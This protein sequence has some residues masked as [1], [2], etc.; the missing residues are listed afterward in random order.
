[1]SL[2]NEMFQ[3]EIKLAARHASTPYSV[4]LIDQ[5][6][7]TL[8]QLLP[9]LSE[10]GYLVEQ[11][12]SVAEAVAQIETWNFVA[13]L[14]DLNVP[15]DEAARVLEQLKAH[16]GD[17][18]ILI[19]TEAADF[20]K[21]VIALRA[22]VADYFLKPIKPQ[23]LRLR[24][25][26]FLKLK[27]TQ[28]ELE[29]RNSQ[30]RFIV[31]HL[32]AGAV[33][34]NTRTNTISINRALEN[35]TGY[36]AEELTTLD[37]WFELLFDENTD[38]IRDAYERAR[39]SQ[40]TELQHWN[41][42]CKAGTQRQLDFSGFL[43]DH[44]EVWLLHDITERARTEHELK[45]RNHAIQAAEN[46]IIICDANLPDQPI[47]FVNAAFEK[48]TGYQA[49]E[50]IGRNARFLQG[51]DRTQPG[52]QEII[53][54]LS[55][56]QA[57]HV[58]MRNYRKNG[59]MFWNEIWI[60]PVKNPQ[61]DITHFI[62]VQ[63]DIT[64]LHNMMEETQQ[65]RDFAESILDTAQA[66]ILVLDND[67]NIVRFNS[68]MEEI[69]GYPLSEVAG[70]DWFDLFIPPT[71]QSEVKNLFASAI[72]QYPVEGHINRIVTKSGNFLTIAWWAKLLYDSNNN[73]RGVLSIGHD[74][75]DYTLAQERALQAERLAAIGQ[76]VTG[77]AHES[78]N[79][80]QRAQACL[81][82]LELDLDNQPEQ[83]DL[84][85]RCQKAL[86][87]L[88]R[89]YE[90]VRSYAAPIKL[91]RRECCLEDIW[92]KTWANLDAERAGRHINFSQQVND[93][94]L[95]C[96]VDPHRMTQV[97]RNIFE[98]SLAVCE[99]TGEVSV[100]CGECKWQNQDALQISIRDNGPGLTG[101]QAAKIF[102]PF[103]TTKQKGTGLGM[104][105]AKRIIEA[106]GGSIDV[107]NRS[108]RG[109]EILITLPR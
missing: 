107:G 79:A 62:A 21:S 42:R 56:G 52:R 28:E 95:V 92:T 83:L 94:S 58:K 1:M 36:S 39:V 30:M 108:Q 53:K 66:I 55:R 67:G 51:T 47:I 31:D 85:L 78:R 75:T 46:A 77:L 91:D 90:E 101:E 74:I 13:I 69:T 29:Q 43:F 20:H 15:D 7:H 27:Q 49:G 70:L 105:I 40:F 72:N 64:E 59:S 60:S 81:E 106:H 5:D 65:Q 3:A 9:V 4:L 71:E 87:D 10:D 26:H 73:L 38:T 99:E 82:M 16:A 88:Y 17:A 41:I 24:M 37:R 18:A 84:T 63:N 68:F 109:A 76:M 22:G 34:V 93:V 23:T 8:E 86:D 103:F 14:V 57:V 44:H 98:N 89:L 33:Y 35:I 54:G 12:S 96:R 97:F 100:R 6:L 50:V 80:L 2:T 104:A 45:I 32:P 48:M 61:G 25:Q 102:Q 11:F 19:I